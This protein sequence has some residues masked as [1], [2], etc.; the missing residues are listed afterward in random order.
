VCVIVRYS[1]KGLRKFE[2]NDKYDRMTFFRDHFEKCRV[3]VKKMSMVELD[4]ARIEWTL[5]GDSS[6]GTVDLSCRSTFMM[7][8]ITGK[9]E[10]HRE[11][12]ELESLGPASLAF[13]ASRLKWSLQENGID[14]VEKSRD[15]IDQILSRDDM[16][17]DQYFVDPMDPK[18]YIQQQDTTF[19]D[20][21][22]LGI[23]LTLIYACVQVL[24]TLEGNI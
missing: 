16:E 9:V 10:D 20:A 5:S 17:S 13:A 8:V 14:L 19:D 18:K 22:Q 7:N 15:F 21:L 11:E 6:L 2:G 1:D 23:V 3:D 24:R 4:T 12:W